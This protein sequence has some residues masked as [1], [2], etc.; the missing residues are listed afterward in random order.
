MAL[1][2]DQ[3]TQVDALKRKLG[4]ANT[5]TDDQLWVLIQT[6]PTLNAVASIIWGEYAASTATL[7]TM[8][9]G[10]SRRNLGD[11]YTQATKMSLYFAGLDSAVA[12]TEGRTR[13]ARIVRS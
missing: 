4:E 6:S 2:E 9:E 8:A 10:S 12:P 3:Q 1:T 11:L 7:V 5:Y 13:T